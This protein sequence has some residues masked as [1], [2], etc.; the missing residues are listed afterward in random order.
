MCVSGFLTLPRF[1]PDPKKFILNCE[2]NVHQKDA[3]GMANS[4]DSDQTASSGAV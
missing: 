4:V 2:Q 3:G 1:L